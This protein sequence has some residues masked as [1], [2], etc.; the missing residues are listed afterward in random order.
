MTRNIAGGL[1]CFLF[2]THAAF[3][4]NTY[5]VT[6]KVIVDKPVSPLLY[7]SFLELGWG[8]ST[9]NMWSELLYN[10]SFEENDAMLGDYAGGGLLANVDPKKAP[11]WH[12]GYEAAK[13]YL[14]KD[15]ADTGPGPSPAMASAV[16]RCT[17]NRLIPIFC[18]ARI[19]FTSEEA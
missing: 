14:H 17:I 15:A 6:N 8:R 12:S 7:S 18:F 5:Y 2:L 3:A 9:D 11:W 16:S 19:V 13:W 4:Q 10:R 1:L